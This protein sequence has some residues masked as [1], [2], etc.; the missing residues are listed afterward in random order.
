MT[1]I[2]SS[3]KCLAFDVHSLR[4]DINRIVVYVENSVILFYIEVIFLVLVSQFYFSHADIVF[5]LLESQWLFCFY[6]ATNDASSEVHQ[7]VIKEGYITSFPVKQLH[8]A[9]VV[10]I[11]WESSLVDER[12]SV[13]LHLN[14]VIAYGYTYLE[15]SINVGHDD[16][17]VF[18][19]WLSVYIY[20]AVLHGDGS[21]G[22]SYRTRGLE[23]RLIGE[24]H[25]AIY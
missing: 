4:L 12:V 1:R 24:I 15:V 13:L 22:E 8:D 18:A 10:L 7:C 17:A 11:L 16:T 3:Y 9:H 25:S 20:N 6:I 19:C 2:F 14:I 23:R 5:A 21:A